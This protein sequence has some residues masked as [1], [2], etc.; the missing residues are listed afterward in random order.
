M[1]VGNPSTNNSQTPPITKDINSVHHPLY[2]H[3]NDHPR[4]VLISKKLTGSEN[5]SSWKRSMMIALNTKNKL[6][7][8]NGEFEEPAIN[9]EIRSVWERAN[10]MEEKQRDTR[11]SSMNAPTA[12]NTTSSN[13]RTS[14]NNPRQY[15]PNNHSGQTP[16]VRKSS[17]KKGVYCTNCSK[18]GHTGEECY[19]IVGYPLGHP[20][21]NKYI[22]PP[23]RNQSRT[24]TVNLV[25][26]KD[27]IPQDET[28]L[29]S[30]DES[31]STSQ[32]TDPYV[33]SRMDHLQNQLNQVLLMM[34]NGQKEVFTAT[35]LP[36]M[37][38]STSHASKSFELVHIDVWG[39]YKHPTCNKCRDFLTIVDDFSRAI[40]TY[41]LPDKH[42]VS[43]TF[44]SFHSYVK[45]QFQTLIQTVRSDNGTEFLNES[46]STFLKSQ[47]TPTPA[48][49]PTPEPSPSPEHTT[50][51]P[52]LE[53]T[54]SPSPNVSPNLQPT[55]SS[56]P[57][58]PVPIRTSTRTKQLPTA[59][60]DYQCGNNERY[61][62]RL[63]AKGFNQKEGIDYKETFAPVAKMVTIRTLLAVWFEKLTTFLIQLGF[64]QSYVD[65][66]LF[67]ITYKGPLTTLLV[68]VDDI[69]L[70]SPDASFITFIKTKLHDMFSIKDLG[71][72]NYYLG[73]EFLRNKTSLAMSQRKYALELLEH[74]EVLNVKPSAIPTDPIVKLNSTDGEP[75]SD[76]SKYRTLVGKLLYLTITRPDLAFAGKEFFPQLTTLSNSLPTVT[77]IG[78]V[79]PSLEDLFCF[80]LCN[81]FGEQLI[82][83]QS[84]KQTV[85]F[86]SSTEAE[87]RAL[88]DSTCEIYW[89]KCLLH[90]LHVHIPT[91]IMMLCDNASTIAL[92][93]NPIHH[94]RTKHIEI[95]CHFVRDKIKEGHI[96]PCFISTKSQIA[97]I[98]T[99]GLCRFLHYNCLSKLVICDPYS[100]PTWGGGYR[101]HKTRNQTP[102]FSSKCEQT[103]AQPQDSSNAKK[104]I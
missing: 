104:L 23:Q 57:P 70:T 4:L 11:F 28:P 19:K 79:V 24:R 42:H 35:T 64:K 67:T 32:T 52:L 98:L 31:C 92:A 74:A 71:S 56:P 41:L 103:S 101:R 6:K 58:P 15:T 8:I 27:Q 3:Q 33:Y 10:D 75:L 54:T 93:N 96:Q 34:Q 2:F 60:K 5:Y 91:P 68:Y 59:L 17:F 20:L 22:P 85:V 44:K 50:L 81:L 48:N 65:T 1:A 99:K 80:W 43:S 76:P 38:V 72:L 95:D 49:S 69:L 53:H 40:W 12:L 84:R 78:L 39:P 36:H 37:S 86:K 21:H 29:T 94:A 66:S 47:A 102:Q 62:A 82:S 90:D 46:L 30:A 100:M 83:W 51:S 63:V 88:A 7:L 55:P 73:I 61:K 26:N 13:H 45:T 87:Y 14:Y 97:D 77:V 25:I 89:L 9:L 16:T 18:E